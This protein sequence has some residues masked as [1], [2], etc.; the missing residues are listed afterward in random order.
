MFIFL[1]SFS[2]YLQQLDG[3]ESE[4]VWL[5]CVL[6]DFSTQNSLSLVQHSHSLSHQRGEGLLRLQ[7]IQKGLQDEEELSAIFTIRKSPAQE[8]G[9]R[10]ACTIALFCFNSQSYLQWFCKAP[11][12]VCKPVKFQG[13]D[14]QNPTRS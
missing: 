12:I 10:H 1:Y 3:M 14:K 7:R 4:D 13:G 2:Q 8:N 6:C 9:T 11:K 5:H